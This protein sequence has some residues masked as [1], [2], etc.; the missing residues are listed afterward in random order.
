MA[1]EDGLPVLVLALVQAH[2]RDLGL[3]GVLEPREDL[4]ERHRVVAGPRL[5]DV[6]LGAGL[7]LGPRLGD[8]VVL[9]VDVLVALEDL[10]RGDRHLGRARARRGAG[11]AKM[12]SSPTGRSSA[13]RTASR[14]ARA[15]PNDGLGRRPDDAQGQRD[16][17]QQ[18]LRHRRAFPRRPSLRLAAAAGQLGLEAVDRLDER[19]IDRRAARRG[20]PRRGRRAARARRR[21]RRSSARATRTRCTPAAPGAISRAVS[22]DALLDARVRVAVVEEDGREAPELLRACPSRRSRC[23]RARAARPRRTGILAFS[24]TWVFQR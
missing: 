3:A 16:R 5:V 17:Q 13:A 14:T 11:A 20:R 19:G 2:D 9:D 1:S 22:V 23:G 4:V 7:A 6:D 12:P 24:L 10:E 18:E 21:A 8:D 15:T